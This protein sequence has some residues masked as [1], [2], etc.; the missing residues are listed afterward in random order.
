MTSVFSLARLIRTAVH[1]FFNMAGLQLGYF[2]LGVVLYYY[3]QLSCLLTTSAVFGVYL[4][5]GGWR[6]VKV[7]IKTLPR[8]LRWVIPECMTV[9]FQLTGCILYIPTVP[10]F[11]TIMCINPF[12]SSMAKHFYYQRK[13]LL[14][15]ILF[16]GSVQVVKLKGHWRRYIIYNTQRNN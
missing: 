3:V 6:F 5:T 9:Y 10:N 14:L 8:D 13:K 11:V 12:M 15:Q 2:V 16:S 4:V 1:G 7:I